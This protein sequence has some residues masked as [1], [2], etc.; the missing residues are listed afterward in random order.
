MNRAA[1]GDGKAKKTLIQKGL[2]K[3]KKKFEKLLQLLQTFYNCWCLMTKRKR[4]HGFSELKK[5]SVRF[6][7]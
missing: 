1:T 6:A 3:I 2:E 5:Q 7:L 4:K